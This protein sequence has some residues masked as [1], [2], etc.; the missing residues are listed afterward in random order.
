MRTLVTGAN[1][2]LGKSIKSLVNQQK[3][4]DSFVFATRDQFDLSN[5]QSIKSYFQSSTFD[6]IINSAAYTS[7][8]KA[9]T[10]LAQAYQVNAEAVK[11]LAQAALNSDIPLL[12]ISTDYVFDGT[13]QSPYLENDPICPVNIYGASKRDCFT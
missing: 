7:V 10:E 9:E 13:K 4:G 12:H 3:I 5:P 8:D 1:G 2:Q 6:L 11:Y